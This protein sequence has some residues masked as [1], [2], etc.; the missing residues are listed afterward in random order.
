MRWP[1]SRAA[2]ALALIGL[3][4]MPTAGC[5]RRRRHPGEGRGGFLVREPG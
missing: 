2:V 3:G 1:N 4:A 5:G